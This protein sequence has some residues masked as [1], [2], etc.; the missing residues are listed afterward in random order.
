M[1][2]NIFYAMNE[3]DDKY[4]INTSWKQHNVWNIKTQVEIIG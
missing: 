3:I 1:K 2:T 4:I